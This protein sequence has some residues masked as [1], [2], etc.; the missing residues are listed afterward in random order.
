M[1]D[2]LE[3]HGAKE[4][5]SKVLGSFIGVVGNYKDKGC[6]CTPSD[7]PLSTCLLPKFLLPLP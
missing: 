5:A 2:Y 4:V 6:I 3:K 7:K 1:T